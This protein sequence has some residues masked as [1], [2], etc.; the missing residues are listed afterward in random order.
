[1]CYSKS[2]KEGHFTAYCKLLLLQ[3]KLS[4]NEKV[5]N[6]EL[7]GKWIDL[8]ANY[9]EDARINFIEQLLKFE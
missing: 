9:I 3:K 1:M 8:G 4:T 5:D 2:A 6:S 7:L